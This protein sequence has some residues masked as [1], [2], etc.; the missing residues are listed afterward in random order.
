M[1]SIP[2]GF[3]DLIIGQDE[4][5]RVYV[6]RSVVGRKMMDALAKR[7]L[8]GYEIAEDTGFYL[9]GR[10]K[11]VGLASELYGIYATLS[12]LIRYNVQPS[13]QERQFVSEGIISILDYVEKHG[14]DASPYLERNINNNLF[15]EKNYHYVGTMTWAM[16]TFISARVAQRQNIIDLDKKTI[17]RIFVQIKRLITL[18]MDSIVGTEENPQGW[19]YTQDCTEPSLFFSYSVIE[20][21]ADLDDFVVN[22]SDPDTELLEFV[23]TNRNDGELLHQRFQNVCF[24]V[25]DRFWHTYKHVL[26]TSL[27]SDDFSE[28][29]T[30]MSVE[31]IANSSRS[32]ALFNTL[33]VVF[34]IFYSYTNVRNVE[35]QNEIV[36][37]MNQALQLVQNTYDKLVTMGKGSIVDKHIIAYNQH[38]STVDY[39]GTELN[40][41]AIS[42]SSIL[43]MLVKANN[44]IARYILKF[45]QQKMGEMF[46]QMLVTMVDGGWV[47]ENRKY[48]LLSTERY[49]EAFADFFDYYERYEKAYA[50]KSTNRSQLE[51]DIEQEI[52]PRIRNEQDE[53][54]REKH[55][56]KIE[57]VKAKAADNFP[58]E[59]LINERIIGTVVEKS[60]EGIKNTLDKIISYNNA[61]VGG[62]KNK[63]FVASTFTAQ[64]KELKGIIDKLM[65]SYI[66][67]SVR[68]VA[69]QHNAS[70][71]E[72]NKAVVAD[73]SGFMHDYVDMVAENIG[74]EGIDKIMMADVVKIIKNN[75]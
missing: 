22:S 27:F 61:P 43:P 21:F 18:F 44:L 69:L 53:S 55:E 30:L 58:I 49:I 9:Y 73:V 68:S 59:K 70:T 33:Y 39:F 1:K 14:Y 54:L 15:G 16:S 17:R 5:F 47:W 65:L 51:K 46:D 52:T 25:G 8:G 63:Q 40:D 2:K 7:R 74:L 19:G 36:S 29:F 28:D 10:D 4:M 37:S 71:D 26:K 56:K 20:A 34:A 6:D 67:D 35:E 62:R 11:T 13:D 50:E 12:L 42:A 38:H 32:S 72:I 31:D 45:P 3:E 64:E 48:E 41:E 24:K 66:N 23:N 75:K 60:M 57:E